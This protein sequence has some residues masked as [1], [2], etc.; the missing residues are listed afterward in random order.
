MIVR[1]R[2][3]PNRNY[4]ADTANHRIRTLTRD[5]AT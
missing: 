5:G 2:V 4:M 1:S 3:Q